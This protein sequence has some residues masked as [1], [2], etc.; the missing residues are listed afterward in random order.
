[1]RQRVMSSVSAVIVFACVAVAS[2]Q[3]VW[4]SAAGATGAVDESDRSMYVFG[5]NGAV[6]IRSSVTRGTLDIRYPVLPLFRTFNPPGDDCT[7]INAVLRDTGPGARV[8]VRLM[9][10]GIRSGIEGPAGQLRS[11]AEI[12]SDMLQPVG[13]SNQYRE[14]KACIASGFDPTFFTYY[15]EVQLI[16]TT[17]TAN[18]GFMAV[19]IC[20][21]D[22]SCDG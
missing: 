21:D 7:N 3:V 14:A 9:E 13:G 22:D 18:P 2:A 17:A 1:M 15:V 11:I 6:A 16:K 10:L 4:W 5:S 12:D 19:G 8:I 20:P